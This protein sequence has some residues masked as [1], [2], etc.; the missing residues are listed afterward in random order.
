MKTLIHFKPPKS[1]DSFTGAR[2][3]K[4]LK[5]ACELSGVTWVDSLLG[6][7][8]IF[9]CLSPE[10]DGK[11]KQAQQDGCKCIV[12]C[13]YCEDDPQC[14]FF[15]K[16]DEG[17]VLKN[18]ALH[19]LNQADL[20]LVPS[21]RIKDE[22]DNAGVVT[23][24][25]VLTPGVSLARFDALSLGERSL[26]Y[27]YF[28]IREDEQFV[29]SLGDYDEQE[30]I[31]RFAW[32]GAACPRTRFIVFGNR[33]AHGLYE[34]RMKRITKRMPRNVRFSGL[35]EDDVFRSGMVGA[36]CFLQL[37]DGHD[38]SIQIL[39]AFAS[40]TLVAY[41]GDPYYDRELVRENTAFLMKEEKNIADIFAPSY[42][43]EANRTIMQGYALAKENNL[44]KL[45][46]KLKD[47]YQRMVG[48]SE[49]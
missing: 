30:T 3:R 22:I 44:P 9:H 43:Q 31:K 46:E 37:A 47:I 41:L 49:E 14:R 12:S 4:V 19:M 28:G 17:L 24:I 21:Q 1:Y 18:K 45:G 8:H 48:E 25:E 36:S 23:S 32:L 40:K 7:P 26:F 16:K 6:F 2:M 39:E 13:G 34:A 20:V 29:V 27:R 33:P 10:D 35:V 38:N 5:G 15:E 42:L 11:L